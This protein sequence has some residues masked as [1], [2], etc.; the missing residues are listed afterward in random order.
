MALK[1]HNSCL[2]IIAD[3]ILIFL[4]QKEYKKPILG[5]EW[6]KDVNPASQKPQKCVNVDKDT[7][8]IHTCMHTVYM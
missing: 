4:L 5:T 2:L 1:V 8:H 6:Q 3:F 7:V